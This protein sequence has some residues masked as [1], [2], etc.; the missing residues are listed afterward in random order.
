[1]QGGRLEPDAKQSRKP[2]NGLIRFRFADGRALLLT[3]PGTERKAGVWA[4]TGDPLHQPPLEGLGPEADEVGA[5]EFADLARAHPMRLHG[6]LRDQSVVAGLGRRLANEVCWHAC[7]SPFAPSAKLGREGAERVVAAI[8][9]A[10]TEGLAVE[11]ERTSMSASADR[12]G[13]VHHHVGDA[14]PRCG[15]TVAAVEY[16]SYTVAYCPTC[17]TAGKVLADNV[18]SRFLK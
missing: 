2:R 1:M 4:L 6:L 8:R 9:T 17:Q 18:T 13:A 16:R 3:E 7:L 5:E 11:R 10:V 12:P 15:D 14:C